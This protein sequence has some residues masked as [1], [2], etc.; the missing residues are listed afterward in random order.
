MARWQNGET[1]LPLLGFYYDPPFLGNCINHQK[2]NIAYSPF[3][4]VAGY[5]Y[6]EYLNTRL[7]VG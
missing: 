5:V 7:H 2:E 1:N 3:D 4:P 6:I